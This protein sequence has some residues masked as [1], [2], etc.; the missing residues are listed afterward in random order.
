MSLISV[1]D[2]V[3]TLTNLAE[4]SD[5]CSFVE[6][7]DTPDQ[8]TCGVT[9]IKEDDSATLGLLY[10]TSGATASV[11][12]GQMEVVAQVNEKLSLSDYWGLRNYMLKV[13]QD[14]KKQK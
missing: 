6:P 12:N 14:F 9:F 4:I 7:P 10:D 3:I 1:V 13:Y 11:F 2:Y 8:K 5:S